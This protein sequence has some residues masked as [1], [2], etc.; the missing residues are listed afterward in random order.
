MTQLT[1]RQML[2]GTAAAAFASVMPFA[3]SKTRRR[4]P[5]RPR[6][7]SHPASTATRLAASR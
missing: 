1:R 6:A 7:S 3:T 5:P 4:C 2:I